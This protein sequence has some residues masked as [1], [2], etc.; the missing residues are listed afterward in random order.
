MDF[1]NEVAGI[2]ASITAEDTAAALSHDD[3]I[4]ATIE[5]AEDQREFDQGVSALEHLYAS[6]ESLIAVEESGEPIN[7]TAASLIAAPTTIST[8][9]VMQNAMKTIKDFIDTCIRIGSDIVARIVRWAQNLKALL[10]SVLKSIATLRATVDNLPATQKSAVHTNSAGL[11]RLAVN[12]LIPRHSRH[13]LN[14]LSDIIKTATIIYGTYAPE[15][16]TLEQK[17][18]DVLEDSWGKNTG[19]DYLEEV[20]DVMTSQRIMTRKLF[21]FDKEEGDFTIGASELLLG[22]KRVVSQWASLKALAKFNEID[23]DARPFEIAKIL[24]R[25]SVRLESTVTDDV[26]LVPKAE[27]F[28]TMDKQE[29]I[30]VLDACA[31]VLGIYDD[32]NN[33]ISP[34]LK[35]QIERSQRVLLKAQM[36]KDLPT[37]VDGTVAMTEARYMKA[38]VSYHNSISKWASEPFSQFAAHILDIINACLRLIRVSVSQYE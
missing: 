34:K 10:P 26:L 8:E 32:F 14:G 30:L 11:A 20:N 31:G 24:Q 17:M 29:M 3:Q 2:S 27:L 22:N 13:V 7:E 1:E 36:A 33:Q 6:I 35:E 19:V 28:A 21:K 16:L 25:S 37:K 4:A 9:S 18:N 15:I 12:N 38:I 23:A 5:V